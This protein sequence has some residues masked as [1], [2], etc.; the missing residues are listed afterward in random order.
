MGAGVYGTTQGKLALDFYK[1]VNGNT[2]APNTNIT[3]TGQFAAG[4]EIWLGDD[5]DIDRVDWMAGV[6]LH[7]FMPSFMPANVAWMQ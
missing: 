5:A 3:V 1:A 6:R 2:A 7:E 4:S